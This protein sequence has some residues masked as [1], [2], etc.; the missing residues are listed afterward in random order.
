MQ[1]RLLKTLQPNCLGFGLFWSI[2]FAM[3]LGLPGI[4]A[5]SS[6]W[7]AFVWANQL[8]LVLG[9]PL[10]ARLLL[11]KKVAKPSTPLLFLI[12][13][14]LA[15]AGFLYTHCFTLGYSTPALSICTSA[16][17]GIACSAFYLLWNSVYASEGQTRSAIY[18][19]AA[20][21]LTVVIC[22]VLFACPRP[23]V[24]LCL[25]VIL[26]FSSTCALWCSARA[27]EPVE[28]RPMRAHLP[29]VAADLWKPVLCAAVVCFVQTLSGHL[30]A[31][32]DDSLVLS[33]LVGLGAACL[34]VAVVG[35]G[36]T[37]DFG[38]H[39]AFKAMF[40]LI[41]IV[42]FVPLLLGGQWMPFM[43]GTLTFGARIMTI[44]TLILCA[45]Y[46]ARTQFSPVAVYLACAYPLH[47]AG[48]VGDSVGF[49]MVAQNIPYM[50]AIRIPVVCL[51][52]CFAAL[53]LVSLGKRPRSLAEPAD[54]TLL[55]NPAGATAEATA[56]GAAAPDAEISG[57]PAG[58][59]AVTSSGT[60]DPS[61]ASGALE[62]SGLSA[63]EREVVD[64]LLKGN[65]LAAISRKLFISE[66]TTRGHMKRIYRK[67][68]VHSRQE[69]IDLVEGRAGDAGSIVPLAPGRVEGAVTPDA[70]R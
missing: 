29:S 5:P 2:P 47:V 54:D 69:L 39:S 60:P 41:G 21:V 15:C 65:T 30:P 13:G 18:L 8:F 37:H 4:S 56:A 63:R 10:C 46:A 19:P 3:L 70:D 22:L 64:L 58:A 28:A 25:T 52:V 17:L 33:M 20:S 7:L 62:G 1:V 61:P 48:F 57:T 53:A 6:D 14:T 32:Y 49:L 31:L 23:L 40:P 26:P 55:I 51:V 45:S 43:V 11:R 16:V 27:M 44:L 50:T 35:V 12:G 36:S 38:T 24:S 67:F 9:I 68:D 34:F 42:L 66:N 59:S